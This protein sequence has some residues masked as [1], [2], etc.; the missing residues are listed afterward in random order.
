MQDYECS[1]VPSTIL[2]RKAGRTA[3]EMRRR[4]TWYLVNVLL[5][6]N[7]AYL[8]GTDGEKMSNV[9]YNLL[10]KD[11]TL[12]WYY[13]QHSVCNNTLIW[14]CIPWM[15]RLDVVSSPS[16]NNIISP[17][18]LRVCTL[19]FP[20]ILK[21]NIIAKHRSISFRRECISPFPYI[22]VSNFQG[23]IFLIFWSN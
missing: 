5:M 13:T 19:Q 4:I 17:G 21:W 10:P 23:F 15:Q 8:V 2:K 20:S 6:C 11:L 22:T 18:A 9:G 16:L 3:A 1:A 12:V 7:F 14:Y